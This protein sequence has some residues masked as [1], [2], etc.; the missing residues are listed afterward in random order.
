[1][2]CES[3]CDGSFRPGFTTYYRMPRTS[4]AELPHIR[5]FAK[6]SAEPANCLFF[7]ALRFFLGEYTVELGG[8]IIW[9]K[10]R[11]KICKLFFKLFFVQNTYQSFRGF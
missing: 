7:A 11:T 6:K 4:A 1:M 8:Y 5:V 2:L 9:K 10:M 3:L